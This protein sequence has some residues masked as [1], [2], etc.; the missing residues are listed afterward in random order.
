MKCLDKQKETSKL[1]MSA[2]EVSFFIPSYPEPVP[3]LFKNIN[4]V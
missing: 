2:F 4:L 1:E 3:E